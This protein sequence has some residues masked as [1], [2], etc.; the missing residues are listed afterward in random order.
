[1]RGEYSWI[2]AVVLTEARR[3]PRRPMLAL[4]EPWVVKGRPNRPANLARHGRAPQPGLASVGGQQ[5]A[6]QDHEEDGSDDGERSEWQ[7]PERASYASG[8]RSGRS[9]R[10]RCAPTASH[11]RAPECTTL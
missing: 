8:D 9:T 10:H 5:Y 11:L 1:M 4:G 2:A 3:I 7:F 6:R